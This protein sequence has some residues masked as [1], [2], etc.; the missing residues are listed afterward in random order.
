[1]WPFNTGDFLIE[2]AACA[3]STVLLNYPLREPLIQDHVFIAE[4]L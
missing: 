4:T 2:V 3:G 1:M